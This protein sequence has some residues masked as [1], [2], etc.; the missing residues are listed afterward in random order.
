MILYILLESFLK[1]VFGI[2]KFSKSNR[3]RKVS[4][5][6]LRPPT[7]L[8]KYTIALSGLYKDTCYANSNNINYMTQFRFA[9]IQYLTVSKAYQL[10]N[11]EK[12]NAE[13]WNIAQV[14]F[15]KSLPC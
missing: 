4:I 14:S 6:N 1:K 13:V 15:Y 10:E 7:V 2:C 5:E 8:L 3:R 11:D 9:D 12:L